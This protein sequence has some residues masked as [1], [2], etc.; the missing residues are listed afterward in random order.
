MSWEFK[1][2]G[3]EREAQIELEGSCKATDVSGNGTPGLFINTPK[4][5]TFIPASE[6]CDIV[7]YF[8]DNYDLVDDDPRLALVQD[9]KNAALVAGYNGPERRRLKIF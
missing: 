5:R 3:W 4:T 8:L 1:C 9:I 2:L 7:R 6:F